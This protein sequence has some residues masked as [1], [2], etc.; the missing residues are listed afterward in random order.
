MSKC[1][2]NIE[3]VG[4]EVSEFLD[5]NGEE[6]N[7]S[8]IS[9][10]YT[11]I[12]HHIRDNYSV[13][14]NSP[15]FND[16]V[17]MIREEM[18]SYYENDT[19]L[20]MSNEEWVSETAFKHDAEKMLQGEIKISSLAPHTSEA[21][22][23]QRE[24]KRRQDVTEQFISDA[25]GEAEAVKREMLL[26]AKTNIVNACFIDRS[27][28]YGT[29]TTNQELN[30]N[31]RKYQQKLLNNILKFFENN[32][33]DLPVEV[34][35][36][37]NNPNWFEDNKST[38]AWEKIYNYAK[39]KFSN[40]Y[41]SK[42]L[43][44]LR[45][46]S[47]PNDRIKLDAYNSFILLSNFDSFLYLLFNDSININNFGTKDGS[48]K[49]S[50]DSKTGQQI[51]S[52][53]T[54][55]NIFLED[56]ADR[57][58]ML[59][60][61]TTQ[62]LDKDGN[63][64]PGEY[65]TF[66]DYSYVTALLKLWAHDSQVQGI[67]F[68][69]SVIKDLQNN[70]NISSKTIKAL[71]DENS[72]QDKSLSGIISSLRLNFQKYIPVI[73]ELYNSGYLDK[74]DLSVLKP[75][76]KKKSKLKTI[77]SQFFDS[78]MSNSIYNLSNPLGKFN[79]F[80]NL[81]QTSDSIFRNMFTQAY[82]DQD[83][84]MYNRM[85]SDL[86]IYKLRTDISNTI[87]NINSPQLQLNFQENLT[88]YKFEQ[89]TS[90]SDE[91]EVNVRKYT[92]PNSTIT[93]IVETGLNTE[94]VSLQVTL[95]G[96]TYNLNRDD[97]FETAMSIDSSI[98]TKILSFCDQL[99]STN[100]MN[101]ISYFDNYILFRDG[102]EQQGLASLLQ[103]CGR[104][105]DRKYISNVI[106]PE[107][108]NFV[109]KY[110][111]MVDL[112]GKTMAEKIGYDR[113]RNQINLNGGKKDESILLAL[114]NA[115]AESMGITTSSVVNNSE[116]KAQSNTALSKLFATYSYQWNEQEMLESSATTD[117]D[118]LRV[119]GLFKE[120]TIVNEVYSKKTGKSKEAVSMTPSEFASTSLLLDFL[121]ALFEKND[122][123]ITT[124]GI[125]QFITSVNSDKG[126]VA[127]M[128]INLLA[129]MLDTNGNSYNYATCD[130]SQIYSDIQRNLGKYYSNI[131]DEVLNTYDTLESE[132]VEFFQS[133]YGKL[134]SLDERV[135][136]YI[137]NFEGYS[138]FINQL[139]QEF[140]TNY[141]Q[142]SFLNAL[143]KYH[144]DNNP[145]NQLTLVQNIHATFNKGNLIA[146]NTLLGQIY[147]Y[148]YFGKWSDGKRI[149]STHS[150]ALTWSDMDQFFGMRQLEMIGS[151][152]ANNSKFNIA[153][154]PFSDN[155]IS[156]YKDWINERGD[157]IIAKVD[158][159]N[160]ASNSD[161]SSTFGKFNPD[162]V[163]YFQNRFDDK[164]NVQINPLIQ[165]YNLLHFM[166]SQQWMATT[167][168]SF[169]GHPLKL[170]IEELPLAAQNLYI[171]YHWIKSMYEE[172]AQFVAQSKRNVSFTA[173]MQQFQLN[174][175]YGISDK[176][177]IAVV[178]D[179]E[180][181]IPILTKRD[182]NVTSWDGA[183]IA[184]PFT[185]YLENNS[186]AGNSSGL[187]KKT[188][189]HAKHEKTGS[190]IIIKTAVFG[191][192]NDNMKTSPD[193]FLN[194]FYK[195]SNGVWKDQNGQVLTDFD[196]TT[197]DLLGGKIKHD[198]DFYF[199]KK[200][201]F[202]QIL[203]INY[204]NSNNLNNLYA[205]DP[206]FKVW[207]SDKME[208]LKSLIT[209]GNSYIRSVVEVD[210]NGN[211]T[212]N[213]TFEIVEN[214]NSNYKAW[215]L[216]GGLNSMEL[217]GNKLI[218][219]EN[220]I[221]AVVECINYKGF[222]NPE[223]ED[224]RTQDDFYQPMKHSQVHYLVTEGAIKQG[225]ANINSNSV[226]NDDS[227]LLSYQ[228]RMLQAGTQL[229]K[230]H[231]ADLSEV[232]LPT[233]IITACAALGYSFTDANSLYKGIASLAEVTLDQIMEQAGVAFNSQDKRGFL[234]K[235]THIIIDNLANSST[236][237]FGTYLC[238]SI[239]KAAKASKQ[240][241][242]NWSE[243][244]LPISDNTVF[245][246]AINA[247][248]NYITKNAIKLKMPGSLSIMTPSYKVMPIYGDRKFSDY[249]DPYKEINISQKEHYDTKPIY[250]SVKGGDASGLEF[251][252]KYKI[253]KSEPIKFV[254]GTLDPFTNKPIPEFANIN[255]NPDQGHSHVWI[256][257]NGQTRV[258]AIDQLKNHNLQIFDDKNRNPQFTY[259]ALQANGDPLNEL[260][261]KQQAL[262]SAIKD[263]TR[264]R[265]K[266]TQIEDDDEYEQ[267]LN[268][269]TWD[270]YSALNKLD[271]NT[272]AFKFQMYY[273]TI[274]FNTEELKDDEIN[275][276]TLKSLINNKQVDNI[277]EYILDGRDLGCYNVRFNGDYISDSSRLQEYEYQLQD[278]AVKELLNNEVERIETF[279]RKEAKRNW[280]QYYSEFPLDLKVLSYLATAKYKLNWQSIQD[281]IYGKPVGQE[282]KKAFKAISAVNSGISVADLVNNI[283]NNLDIR[284]NVNDQDVRNIVLDYLKSM[285]SKTDLNNMF[286]EQVAEI[287]KSQSDELYE[288][289]SISEED[290]RTILSEDQLKE[291]RN[292][293]NEF[294]KE[295]KRTSKRFQMYD[296]ASVQDLHNYKE[297][298]PEYKLALARQRRDLYVLSNY[299]I[300]LEQKWE[301]LK[302]QDLETIVKQSKLLFGKDLFELT[303][304]LEANI[305]EIEKLF[306][307]TVIVRDVNPDTNDFIEYEVTI[308]RNS[309][310]HQDYEAVVPKIYKTTFGLEENT[311]LAEIQNNPYYFI[312]KIID[313]EDSLIDDSLFNVEIKDIN[314]KHKYITFSG[315]VNQLNGFKDVTNEIP[316]ITD[317]DGKIFRVDEETGDELYEIKPGMQIYAN[318]KGVEVIVLSPSTN[319]QG[320]SIGIYDNL[321]YLLKELNGNDIRFSKNI[322][323]LNSVFVD[324]I[325]N[326]RFGEYIQDNYGD[327][328]ESINDLL[329]YQEGLSKI[330][331]KDIE[332]LSNLLKDPIKNSK[333]ISRIQCS[334]EYINGIEQYNSFMESLKIIAARIPS[335]NMASFMGMKI[336][337]FSN[338]DRNTAY[339][340]DHQIFLQGSDFDIDSVTLL[341]YDLNNNGKLEFWSPYASLRDE[342]SIEASKKIPFPTGKSFIENK[343]GT[344]INGSQ[345]FIK[346]E[347]NENS[348]LFFDKFIKLFN[349]EIGND[350][351]IKRISLNIPRFN[352]NPSRLINLYTELF[353]TKE[354]YLNTDLESLKN[355]IQEYTKQNIALVS[356]ENVDTIVNNLIKAIDRHNTYLSNNRNMTNIRRRKIINNSNLS[357]MYNIITDPINLQQS[358]TSVDSVT[359]PAKQ[360]AGMSNKAQKQLY[361]GPGNF[362]S[363]GELIYTNF[364]GK[365]CIAKSASSIKAF[366]KLTHYFNTVLN[367]GDE[368]EQNYLVPNKH[369]FNRCGQFKPLIA[370]VKAT[371]PS[372]IISDELLE[373]LLNSTPED[374]SQNLSA[375][376]G[377][378][379]DNAKELVLDKINAGIDMIG[380]Y[381][382]GISVG[383]D[384]PSLSKILMSK[385]SDVLQEAMLGNFISGKYNNDNYKIFDYFNNGPKNEIS[386]FNI[387]PKK[388][389]EKGDSNTTNVVMNVM[390]SILQWINQNG[391]SL[392]QYTP[393]SS[394]RYLFRLNDKLKNNKRPSNKLIGQALVD[395]INLFTDFNSKTGYK[396][397]NRMGINEFYNAINQIKQNIRPYSDVKTN[398]ILQD[399]IEFIKQYGRQRIELYNAENH[400]AT[401]SLYIL[402]TGSK[403][404]QDIGQICSLNQGL[405]NNL[406]TLIKKVNLFE[407]FA[408]NQYK[409]Y[410]NFV[411]GNEV[412]ENQDNVFKELKVNIVK[413]IHDENYRKKCIS[414]ANKYKIN[415]NLYHMVDT[416]PDIKQYIHGLGLVDQFFKDSSVRY[417]FIRDKHKEYYNTYLL[418]SDE[419]TTAMSRYMQSVFI[420]EYLKDVTAD[421]FRFPILEGSRMFQNGQLTNYKHTST[422]M[423]GLDSV[424]GIAYFKYWM[425]SKV[426]PDLKTRDNDFLKALQG[427]SRNNTIS[428]N[429]LIAY[430]LQINMMPKK[431]GSNEDIIF[432][433]YLNKFNNMQ[434]V[435]EYTNPNTGEKTTYNV[436]DLLFYYSLTAFEWKPSQQSLMQMFK[437][438]LSNDSKGSK[439]EDFFRKI[440]QLEQSDLNTILEMYDPNYFMATKN[441]LSNPNANL[442]WKYNIETGKKELY[443]KDEKEF[444]N[445]EEDD[446]PDYYDDSEYYDDQVEY[447]DIEDDGTYII[448]DSGI[449]GYTIQTSYDPNYY[450]F[451]G[452][453]GKQS[454]P[455]E[456][457]LID[458]QMINAKNTIF[459][460][461][462][463]LGITVDPIKFESLIQNFVKL[464]IDSKGNPKIEID[465]AGIKD[466]L[467]DK[468][469]DTCTLF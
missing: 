177:N 452:K 231:H 344:K 165:R 100:F 441:M 159:I 461:I 57:I 335:Q 29:P 202:Y 415:F 203:D 151:L 305:L 460:L 365:N 23:Y 170:K 76:K 169:I 288:L 408:Q 351:L 290:P 126:T 191:L 282:E 456:I 454:K 453:G 406:E 39:S 277:T 83:G 311:N 440:Q 60:I 238:E 442:I 123:R 133:K 307:N 309:I 468:Q 225:A 382:Y 265:R 98:K 359:K 50:F 32:F 356:Q 35:E 279:A 36:V 16:F 234:N 224:I 464:N 68:D 105:L 85:L 283:Y 273:Q 400:E 59:L 181:V 250:D 444:I 108:S 393:L 37:I 167:V 13:D 106:L 143:T 361:L 272:G 262:F 209:N 322:T 101:D 201:R 423:S 248:T 353:N 310:E 457:N 9:K 430:T 233:Q 451:G 93:M 55:D 19:G 364:T 113:I 403:S 421:G 218:P 389:G 228:I 79:I 319:E 381:L 445:S 28:E 12:I 73:A 336:V 246:R 210:K 42:I 174:D 51:K 22:V 328:I 332:N 448:K 81:C 363:Y 292:N 243:Q 266:K 164:H 44:N 110:K 410:Q 269:E 340:S 125:A 450:M 380:L 289:N 300:D 61:E 371:N 220:S 186:L 212:G 465:E 17:S 358:M 236:K 404:M 375:L 80:R 447:D 10:V 82:Q 449:E 184:D 53:R 111:Y 199:S 156:E 102:T 197:N 30:D 387:T 153:N 413:F 297:N 377:L 161:Y 366:F 38:G 14:I 425:E 260:E 34:L 204:M 255:Y 21:L 119:P 330:T 182:N 142:E 259:F 384:I 88:Q 321:E 467:E 118:I 291:I 379:A 219:S 46:S 43:N 1:P 137:S 120:I 308:N 52:F 26:E 130:I 149:K 320:E 268:Q 58:T 314:G 261:I 327:D 217:N 281:E 323:N 18:L 109:E 431:E 280:E 433:N 424:D 54:D 388:S 315:Y 249:L 173:Q 154:L 398:Y 49:Y 129:N 339:V 417:K 287:I 329:R 70:Y 117:M 466:Y 158:G 276:H 390:N 402:S 334:S 48:N 240:D 253:I 135:F 302:N 193:T 420:Q 348:K 313:N 11:D 462:T 214:V 439:V 419:Q 264:L 146:S 301:E 187:T 96:K 299:G 8:S 395:F 104:V 386:R 2:F 152:L 399:F 132:I 176:Y 7:I 206:E 63:V 45:Q 245:N 69:E 343:D 66:Q 429:E 286:Y 112:Y 376:L 258:Y 285:R 362:N 405:P 180:R 194:L 172:S 190:G 341:S 357:S 107:K 196:L 15:E 383:F 338:G 267:R 178:R 295:L 274:V 163:N 64:I 414:D 127:K 312:N 67:I 128:N 147:R 349:F 458:V 293:V 432:K 284:D 368:E 455:I 33:T 235:C 222:K 122:N 227:E 72:E 175:L 103:Y 74:L 160:L 216:F 78:R 65:L 198:K 97:Q 91:K 86:S 205:N 411:F 241:N 20:D 115:K 317:E 223:S 436:K 192:S 325:L 296:L 396:N 213:K 306:K 385:S 239:L 469:P 31:L 139:N 157:L 304:G 242:F 275:Y 71:Y 90:K 372:K 337:A 407:Q 179:L 211:V 25:Y 116:N 401:D 324:T 230:E 140:G 256:E 155:I 428:G 134:I 41:T 138:N 87:N 438:A 355:S 427:S 263:K 171:K 446:N 270:E 4:G 437:T 145:D 200:G 463:D 254:F 257:Y 89:N 316:F 162:P 331:K 422:I 303:P 40:V 354:L 391:I 226:Y 208:Q 369:I 237:N 409:M 416:L 121:P 183:T 345:T 412:D 3:Q 188:F 370:N 75:L 27:G 124:N 166:F 373:Q 326:S 92:I 62:M 95:D 24:G 298:T 244:G 136:D 352:R 346:S 347:D 99:L 394:E 144:N 434:E 392:E 148:G 84:T 426:I 271:S 418:K 5:N 168:G 215:K 360:I 207:A 114:A 56:E 141:T 459:K 94:D 47:N 189:A 77:F 294:S 229:D 342:K 6:Y 221:K 435:Y 333:E 247:L 367:S 131:L 378:S 150:S 350:G 251:G 278:E 232:S 443:K 318:A 195:M 252:H 374:A 397:P 185:V